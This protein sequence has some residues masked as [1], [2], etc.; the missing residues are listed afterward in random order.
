MLGSGAAAETVI[1]DLTLLGNVAAAVSV[2]LERLVKNFSQIRT[3]TRMTSREALDFAR[4][5]I[6]IYEELG[7]LLGKTPA[8]I[9]TMVSAADIT[10]EMVHKAF[11]QMAGEGGRLG[12]MMERL[13]KTVIGIFSNIQDRLFII[14]R[15]MGKLGFLDSARAF[16]KQI[17]TFLQTNQDQIVEGAGKALNAVIGL[18]SDM[19][20]IFKALVRIFRG[21]AASVGGVEQ[22]VRLLFKAFSAFVALRLAF[23]FG[24]I[25]QSLG[26]AAL[27]F[28]AMGT[29]AAMANLKIMLIPLAIA[30]IGAAIFLLVD[31]VSAFM[32]NAP[33]MTAVL[34][35]KFGFD[36][37]G[38][39]G[40][41]Q[42]LTDAVANGFSQA[43]D[44]I[45]EK[46]PGWGRRILNALMGLAEMTAA[47]AQI[48]F[49]I[50][51]AIAA[52]IYEGLKAQLSGTTLGKLFE[53]IFGPG[54]LGVQTVSLAS[55]MP[56]NMGNLARL[57]AA[58]D[59]SARIENIARA[60][61]LQGRDIAAGSFAPFNVPDF[62][63]KLFPPSFEMMGPPVSAAG[64]GA[65]RTVLINSTQTINVQGL[66]AD[67]AKEAARKG[68]ADA[69]ASVF[70]NVERDLGQ[71]VER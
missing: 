55:L 7:T 25:I 51:T 44:K 27:A 66:S 8:E 20:E 11:E 62:V 22:A 37:K 42:A 31:D 28:R 57:A 64:T 19:Q 34:I 5:G 12:G 13:S 26:K 10:Y 14:S 50:G 69:A 6:P 33:S 38:R 54:G 65:G 2:P 46:A 59:Q 1:G 67:A 48:G 61:G 40:L 70:R 21:M 49:T 43:M 23:H 36:E 41:S 56:G 24:V 71:E 60:F 15:L 53:T 16:V 35:K 17:F 63:Q 4:A 68:F 47:M 3:Q 52:G 9:Q 32:Q 58:S 45:I 39:A 29:A 18:F 30:A